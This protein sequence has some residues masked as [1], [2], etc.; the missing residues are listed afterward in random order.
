MQKRRL[1]NSDMELTALGFGAWAI[2][3]GGWAFAWGAQDDA[4]SIEAIQRAL[5]SGINWVD[6]AAVYGLGH[7]E[8]VVARALKGRDKRPYVFTKCGMVWDDQG[9]VRRRLKADSVR[10]EC[11]SSLRRLKVDAIDL[12]QVHWP[13]EDGAELEEGWTALAE[14]QRQG[15]VRWLGVSNFNV[16]QLEQVRRIAPVTSLQPPYSLIHR[17]IED[18]LLPYC[19]TQG[20]GVIVYSPMASGLLTGAMTRE[21]IQAMP[22]DDWRRGSAD[23]QEPKLSHH[24]SLVER[25]REVGARHGRSP[26]EVALAWTLRG[27]AV[28]AAIVGARSAKQVDGFIQAGDFRLT[29]EEVREV[30]EVL[31]SGSAMAP[32]GIYA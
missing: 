7:S 32:G 30:E 31:G 22:D 29:S 12:Y 4:Q 17:D 10:R 3:G 15:K 11:E 14:L 23:F 13:V 24:L 2:G 8:D 1:G 6:T 20:I 18:D 9:K 25:M 28:T 26:A 19:Q 5:D 27:P 16:S 21:R